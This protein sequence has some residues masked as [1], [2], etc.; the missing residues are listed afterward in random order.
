MNFYISDIPEIFPIGEEFRKKHNKDTPGY[1]NDYLPWLYTQ[2]LQP[3][4]GA[5]VC[6]VLGK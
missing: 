5:N 3:I 1:G 2:P 4:G 6:I